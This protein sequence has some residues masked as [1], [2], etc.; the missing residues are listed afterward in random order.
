MSFSLK[1]LFIFS[2]LLML[3]I[4]TK[5]GTSFLCAR[6]KLERLNLKKKSKFQKHCLK[7]LFILQKHQKILVFYEIVALNAQRMCFLPVVPKTTR[8]LRKGIFFMAS[9][10]NASL[11]AM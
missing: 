1:H 11:A 6:Q 8:L 5:F 7:F 2:M 10:V 4:Y 9:D 3:L